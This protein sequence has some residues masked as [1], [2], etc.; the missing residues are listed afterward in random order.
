MTKPSITASLRIR[1]ILT[2]VFIVLGLMEIVP[3]VLEGA[4]D[5]TGD[6]GRQ[7]VVTQYVIRGVNPFPVAMDALR[8]RYGVLAPDG[9][10][11]MQ[12]ARV[13]G[14]P[15]SG[16]HPQTDPT[17]GPPEATYHPAAVMMLAPLGFL[18][19][20]VVRF[21]W[22]LLNIALL[23]LVARE[24]KSLTGAGEA[25]FL[26]FLGMVAIWPASS[27]C[28]ERE[29]FSLLSLGCILVARRLESTHP[30][31]A[32]LLYSLSLVKPSL[33]IPFLFLPLL[34]RRVDRKST[35]LDSSHPCISY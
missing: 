28:I 31:T 32:G 20:D 5:T 34:D 10:V 16:P 6:L 2:A 1:S 18:P 11:H 23:F 26:F 25:S 12:D 35:R 13:Y 14:I 24:L 29:Q 17:F 33:A 4:R 9:P 15:K 3:A 22:L 21:L 30:I 27:S 19:R 7:W 8:A